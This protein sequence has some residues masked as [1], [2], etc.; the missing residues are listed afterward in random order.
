MNRARASGR[1]LMVGICV[2]FAG[3]AALAETGAASDTLEA[4]TVTAK[5]LEETLPQQLAAYGTRVDTVTAEDIKNG[6]FIDVAETLQALSPGLS[7]S[8]KNGPFD[9]VDI[10]L[11]GSRTE[12]VLWLVDGVRINN[13]LYSGT[14][15]LDTV[16]AAMAERVEVMEGGQALFYGT[17]AVAGAVNIVTKDFSDRRDAQ[18][19]VGADSLN[20]RHVDG[21]A[22]DSIGGNH[23][24]IYGSSD[25][26]SGYHAFRPQ[27]YQPSNTDRDR[28]YG[29]TTLGGKYAYDFT[30][31]LRWNVFYQHTDAELDFAQPFRVA[32]DVNSRKEDLATM[33]L[34]YD[35]SDKASLYVKAYYHEWSTHYD[36]YYN[37]LAKPG[38]IDVLYEDAFWGYRDYGVNA[39]AKFAPAGGLEYYAGYDMQRYTGRDE[40]LVIQQET[41]TTNA[42]FGQVRT[43]HELLENAS[44]A[45]GARYNK[46]TTGEPA[47]IWNA[48]GRYD[49]STGVFVRGTIGTNFR[50]PDAEELYADDPLDERGNPNLKPETSRGANLSVG[51]AAR[52]FGYGFTWEL[53]GF[54]RNIS[55]LIDYA[56]FDPVTNQDVFG[57][58]PGVVTVRGAEAV[59][60]A[61]LN[62]YWSANLSYTYS[63]SRESGGQPLARVPET[64]FKAEFDFH[65]G[66][67]PVGAGINVRYTGTEYTNVGSALVNYG[68]FV[69]VDL[70]ARYFFDEERHHRLTVA[71]DNVFDEE[72]GRPAQGCADTPTDG[73]Y[74]C[75][76][77]YTYVN[78]GLPRMLRASYTYKF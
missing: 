27:D 37:D 44:F 67:L 53:I 31:S 23:F 16:P 7:I 63:R 17:Q 57:N 14:T 34:D 2:S 10:S 73:P 11:L 20:G 40:V 58:V 65:P 26:S 74:D 71:V 66:S 36:T 32:R 50:L 4:V 61:A 47:A 59:V 64:L 43:T 5:H 1:V 54:A 8:S 75:S 38:T 56:T 68:N 6:A 70:S 28:G 51:G 21:Y 62:D 45:L 30:P 33:K 78:R 9:Y 42:V 55:D 12:D 13:R 69:V 39:L 25:S 3:A 52:A 19:S 15:P 41:A 49:W 48:M 77:P 60:S 18:L 22:R 46:P 76:L 72:Y 35:V 24:V 29:V